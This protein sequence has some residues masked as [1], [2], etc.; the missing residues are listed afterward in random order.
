VSA[1]RVH[2][3]SQATVYR[4]VRS[5]HELGFLRYFHGQEGDHRYLASQP[6]HYHH[7]VCQGC[8]KA[9]EVTDCDLH[10]LEKLLTVKTGYTVGGHYLE[11]FGLCPEC[12]ALPHLHD[13]R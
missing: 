10:I 13:A 3:I 7:L 5:L 9:T 11:F 1:L 4:V 2:K 8:G 6:G 12:G